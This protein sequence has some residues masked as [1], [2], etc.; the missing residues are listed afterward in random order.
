M[1]ASRRPL[2]LLVNPV[3]GGKPGSGQA[4][5]D[6]PELL[7]PDA[8]AGG[9]RR[10]GCEVEVRPLREDDDI[11]ELTRRAA[12]AG[13]DVVAAG[14]DGTVG[15]AARAL[16]GHD[17]A[18]LG[19]LAAGSFNNIAHGFR[20]P[21]EL[22][23]ALDAI[24]HGERMMVDVGVARAGTQGEDRLFLEAAGVGLDAL[25]FMALELAERRGLW[26]GLRL[27]WRGMR[28]RRTPVRIVADGDEQRVATPAVT[29]ANGPYLGLGF[30]L[31]ADADPI[32]GLLNVAVF[33]G[34]S[35]FEVLR[36][37]IATS[38]RRRRHHP[39]VAIHTAREVM[40]EGIRGALPV[41]A[42]GVAIGVTPATFGVRP[43]A[44]RIL[45]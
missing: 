25:G 45:R 9:L 35:P 27:L 12:D 41:H 36:H 7:T 10:R 39:R 17:E 8:L 2:L 40:V 33:H 32:D 44:L 23:P 28:R 18:A 30:A 43:R 29:V 24:A 22:E 16:V 34:M 21:L 19:I 1:S 26:R 6:D 14:G 37:F 3:S 11:A 20:V 38:R 5:A 15:V 42:D 4:L 31:A 13:R